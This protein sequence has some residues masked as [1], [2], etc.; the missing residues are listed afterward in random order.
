MKGRYCDSHKKNPQNFTIPPEHKERENKFGEFEIGPGKY[1][2][3]YNSIGKQFLGNKK[4]ES[5]FLFGKENRNFFE[6]TNKNPGPG[7]Y[8]FASEFKN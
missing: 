5:S 2:I 1:E 8:S 7:S 6:Q 3:G 4:T